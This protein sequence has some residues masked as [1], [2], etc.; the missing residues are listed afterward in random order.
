MEDGRP[1]GRHHQTLNDTFIETR[2]GRPKILPAASPFTKPTTSPNSLKHQ[3][4]RQTVWRAGRK[5]ND[6]E[7]AK[8]VER[9]RRNSIPLE[10]PRSNDERKERARAVLKP[11]RHHRT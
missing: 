5:Q 4:V 9:F 6:A 3:S 2:T 7:E 11:F 10:Q 8:Q 1:T